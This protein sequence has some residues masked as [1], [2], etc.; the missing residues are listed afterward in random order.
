MRGAATRDKQGGMRTSILILAAAC[1]AA[2]GGCGLMRPEDKR[3]VAQVEKIRPG[4]DKESVFRLLGE[5]EA[6][7]EIAAGDWWAYTMPKLNAA[8]GLRPRGA[9]DQR[10]ISINFD[11]RKRVKLCAVSRETP[12]AIAARGGELNAS[13]LV[14]CAEINK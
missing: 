11:A 3:P 5:P 12:A 4:M 7:L 8:A 1:G 13:H 10:T 14:T 6:T 2:L 9:A